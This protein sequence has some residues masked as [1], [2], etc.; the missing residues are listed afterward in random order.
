MSIKLNNISYSYESDTPLEYQALHQI[1]LEIDDGSYTAIVGHTG[2]GKSTLLQHFNGLL[3]PSEGYLSVNGLKIDKDTKNRDLNALRKDVGFIFQFPES[4]LF[5]E[6]VI[7]DIAF[8]PKNFGMSDQQAN[9]VAK[10]AAKMVG[11]SESLFE[12]SPFELSGGQMRRVAIAGIIAMQPK[13]LILDEPTAGL[14]P[15]GRKQIMDL[16]YKLHQEYKMTI[17]LVT[18]Q[19]N[20]VADYADHVIVLEDGKKIADTTPRE[21]FKNKQWIVKHHLSLPQAMEFAFDLQAKGIN[22]EKMPLTLSELVDELE[23]RG[24]QH[25]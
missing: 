23:K 20:D 3:K 1:S 9:E 7:K 11:L 21:L 18:H 10:K 5:E 14:D 15:I 13:I 25:E 19:M 16:F 24:I 17:I 22:F 8:A 12:K 6:T 4:Q 2:S